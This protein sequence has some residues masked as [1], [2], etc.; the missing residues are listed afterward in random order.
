MSSARARFA[1]LRVG[2]RFTPFRAGQRLSDL[3]FRRP[4][5]A[6]GPWLDA[7][8]ETFRSVPNAPPEPV[9]RLKD[10]WPGDA[11]RA[12]ALIANEADLL[13]ALAPDSHNPEISRDDVRRARAQSF[14]WLRDLRSL[15]GDAARRTARRAVTAWIE[16][17]RRSDRV[18]WRADVVGQR[19][20]AWMGAYDFFAASA[21]PGFR[22][23]VMEQT[24]MQVA[25]LRRRLNQAPPGA[26][27]IGALAGLAAGAAAID[28]AD[29]NFPLIDAALGAL[30]RDELRSDGG[31]VGATPLAQLEALMRLVDLRSAFAASDRPPPEN[32]ADVASAM[33][34]PLAA[35]RLGDGGLAVFGGG[36]GDPWTIDLALAASGWRGRAPLDLPEAGCA[37]ALAGRST[38]LTLA[39]SGALEFAHGADRLFSSIGA[40]ADAPSSR[41]ERTDISDFSAPASP[42]CRFAEVAPIEREIDDGA[43]LLTAAWRWARPEIDWRRRIYLSADGHDLRGEDIA[44]GPAGRETIVAFH[45]HPGAD[46]I[47]LDDGGVLVRAQSGQGWRFRA[48]APAF[49]AAEPYRGRPGPAAASMRIEVPCR[50]DKV[51][52]LHLRWALRMEQNG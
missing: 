6:I 49:L 17:N 48:D 43:T 35:L 27:R 36:E 31:L 51:G 45:L 7:L 11:A 8:A 4:D 13:A 25:W 2:A 5:F 26:G 37:R 22:A 44:G 32:S 9:V 16:T 23:E 34:A 15:G 29:A 50:S 52:R 21:G 28:E 30:A 40:C 12:E 10:P 3:K 39:R 33:A 47:Q 19:L 42:G 18:A 1:S 41:F 46:A 14:A 38:L 20:S 24:A